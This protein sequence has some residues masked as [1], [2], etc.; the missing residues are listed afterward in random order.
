MFSL[1]PAGMSKSKVYTQYAQ[2]RHPCAP[3]LAD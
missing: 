1:Y 2:P 3:A